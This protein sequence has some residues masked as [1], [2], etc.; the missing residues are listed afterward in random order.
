M[1][2][3]R[4]ISCCRGLQ[5]PPPLADVAVLA[6]TPTTTC[7]AAAL[8]FLHPRHMH[9]RDARLHCCQCLPTAAR[10]ECIT[11]LPI[12]ILPAHLPAHGIDS[13]RCLR[14]SVAVLLFFGCGYRSHVVIIVMV[15]TFVRYIKDVRMDMFNVDMFIVCVRGFAPVCGGMSLCSLV[16]SP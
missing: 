1:P 2:P 7:F 5:P 8:V 10:I 12:T 13:L 15:R 6:N 11:I 4:T 3:P 14:C 9:C 16:Q